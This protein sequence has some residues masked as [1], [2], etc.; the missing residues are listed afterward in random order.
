MSTAPVADP[1]APAPDAG[2]PGLSQGARIVN[3]FFAPS[4]T[5]DDIK[6]SAAWWV[7]FLLIAIVSVAYTVTVDKKVG[8][9]Q[10]ME[11]AMRKSPKQAEQLQSLPSDQREQRMQVVVKITRIATYLSPVISILI[12]MILAGLYMA[13]CNFGAGAEIPFKQALAVVVYSWLPGLFKILLATVALVAGIN[14]EGFD[15]ENPVATNPG[16]FLNPFEHPVLYALASSLDIFTIWTC[17]L[18]AIGLST[19]SKLK[20]S[21]TLAVVFGWLLLWVLLKV[22]RAA[23]AS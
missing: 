10:V 11:N 4:K 20:R 2:Q 9:Q 7:P 23:I 1:A 12:F 15:I 3:T 16:Y 13:T 21:T 19:V 22:A 8:F 6:R 17:I 18:V 14:P 5:F